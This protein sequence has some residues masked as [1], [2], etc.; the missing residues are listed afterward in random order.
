MKGSRLAAALVA[1]PLIALL[2]GLGTWQLQRLAWKNELIA[3]MEARLDA[4]PIALDEALALASAA[5]AWRRVAATGR[6]LHDRQVALY[7]LSAE[8]EPGYL[9]L[10][11]LELPDGGLVLVDRG[12]VP[13][14]L[15]EPEMRPGSEP[16]GEVRVTGVLRGPERPGA[17]TNANDP[18]RGQWHWIDLDALSDVAGGPLLPAVIHADADPEGG[19]P[20]GGQALVR[21]RNEHLGYALTWYALAAAAAVIYVLLLLRGRGREEAR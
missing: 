3:T 6:F 1:L 17:F 15:A 11:P 20:R 5:R 16:E 7:R 2:A 10:T 13:E 4:P 14:G 12:H 21:P 19:W 18:E 9:I 8:G